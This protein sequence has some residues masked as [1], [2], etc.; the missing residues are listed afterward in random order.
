[1][2]SLGDVTLP[3]DYNCHS[4]RHQQQQ[5]CRDDVTDDVTSPMYLEK[6]VAELIET[7]RTYVAE[8]QQIVQVLLIS[9]PSLGVYYF[10]SLTPSVRLSVCLLVTDKL[11]I[12]SSLLFLDGIEPFFGRQFSMTSCTKR[13]FSILDLGPLTPKIYS[14][15]FAQNHL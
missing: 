1:M 14:P 13:F 7:E 5:L 2:T 3:D 10:W 4:R 12:D 6:I 15:K 9:A 8:L 11:Q